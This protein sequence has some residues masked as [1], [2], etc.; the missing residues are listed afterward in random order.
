MNWLECSLCDAEFG[1]GGETTISS[2][3]G[4]VVLTLSPSG[5]EFSV[6]FTCSLSNHQTQHHSMEAFNE[7]SV[8]GPGGQQQVSNLVSQTEGD[9]TKEIHREVEAGEMRMSP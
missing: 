4:Q 3:D 9:K 6:E 2:E 5:E 1:P 8:G 7:D